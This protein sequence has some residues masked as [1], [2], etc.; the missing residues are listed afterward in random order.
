MEWSLCPPLTQQPLPC[1]EGSSLLLGLESIP[2]SIPQEAGSYVE[3]VTALAP[4]DG[5]VTPLLCC[6]ALLLRVWPEALEHCAS[7]FKFCKR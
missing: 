3:V 4:W 1:A 2:F 5:S 7:L 6:P